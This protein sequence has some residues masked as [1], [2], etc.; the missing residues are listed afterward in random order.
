MIE[1]PFFIDMTYELM[2]GSPPPDTMSRRDA[3]NAIMEHWK[4]TRI[5]TRQE[6]AC[7]RLTLCCIGRDWHAS[8]KL[9]YAFEDVARRLRAILPPED[10][11]KDIRQIMHSKLYSSPRY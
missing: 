8:A 2:V 3:S 1:R 4:K 11:E 7:A 6:L 10:K 9:P 5:V